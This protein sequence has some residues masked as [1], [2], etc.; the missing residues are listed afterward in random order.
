MCVDLHIHSCYSDGTASPEQLVKM[1]S[2]ANLTAISLTD[3][4]TVDGTREL[5]AH[6]EK[7]DITVIPGLEVSSTH[8]EY[9][10]HILG[11][12]IDPEDTGLTAWL[13]RL[14]QG[15]T[16]RNKQIIMKIQ[17]L[18]L[19]VSL[20]DLE[21][22]ST[23]GQTGRPHIANLLLNK[24]I[25][26][27]VQDAFKYYLR[28]GAPAWANR[29]TYTAAQSIEAI[30]RAGGAAVLA[31][32]GQLAPDLKCLPL[33][34]G[35]LVERGL[36]GI[37]V[38]YPGHSARIMH[39]L[40][41]LAGRYGLVMTGGSDYHGANKPASKMANRENGFCPPDSILDQ[42]NKKT[43]AFQDCNL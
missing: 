20:D 33:L 39:R 13:K 23:C 28:K 31:H 35:E 19:D 2:A 32:P 15:R 6:A 10:L 30:H 26:G 34:L 25:V 37:E 22:L 14:Q 8:R 3:H 42:L 9:S 27:N 29:F 36:D 18:G 4:D 21:A 12:G 1:A 17:A 24:E 43:G 16:E 38:F 40:K 5:A 41:E 7:K 11:Y